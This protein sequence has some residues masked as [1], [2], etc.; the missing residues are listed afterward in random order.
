MR[1][2]RFRA[3][4]T[5]VT[6]ILMHALLLQ[7]SMGQRQGLPDSS[8][9]GDGMRA[10]GRGQ[11]A[12]TSVCAQHACKPLP[13]DLAPSCAR[14]FGYSSVTTLNTVHLRPWVNA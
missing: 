8:L 6:A 13:E 10:Q 4:T 7:V 11:D 14:N 12:Y 5:H 3:C 9:R 2:S 1:S